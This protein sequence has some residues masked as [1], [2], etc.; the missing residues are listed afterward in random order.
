MEQLFESYVA[1]CLCKTVQPDW[2]LQTQAS[3]EYLCRHQPEGAPLG[4][5]FRL[6]PDIVLNSSSRFQVLD[7]KWKVLDSRNVNDKYGLKQADFYQ[8]FAY[9]QT[10]M[11]GKG[12]MMLVYPATD[13]FQHPLPVFSFDGKLR[14][15]VVPFD[16]E[17]G[18]LVDGKYR[19]SFP[20]L[21]A[22]QILRVS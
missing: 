19:D 12:D 18:L 7:T 4:K 14:L 15:W 22:P 20:S 17:R 9:G 5:I 2:Y 3:T 1:Q 21:F 10:Y 8:M 11:G 13:S 16:L 6:K